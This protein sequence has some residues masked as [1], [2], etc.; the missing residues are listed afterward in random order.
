[1]EQN[2]ISNS[3]IE[4]ARFNMVQQQIRPW[5][6]SIPDD[7]ILNLISSIPREDFV[8]NQYRHLAF[9]DSEIPIGFGQ[10]MMSPKMEA[11]LLQVLNIKPHESVLEIGTGSG[12]LTALLANLARHVVTVEIIPELKEQAQA[13]LKSHGIVNVSCESG[14]ASQG[15]PQNGSYDV[16]VVTGSIP[17]MQHDFRE[18]LNTGGRLFVVVGDA[19]VMSAQLIRCT[20]KNQ[21]TQESLFETMLVPLSNISQPDRFIF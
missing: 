7:S 10:T 8:A 5:S 20:G 17:T 1:M 15:W 12:Y 13:K 16:I 9:S 14:D 19:P 11:R 6:S 4:T 3:S 21:W 2:N 18:S